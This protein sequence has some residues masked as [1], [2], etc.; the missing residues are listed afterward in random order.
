MPT[1]AGRRRNAKR[2][3]LGRTPL[4]NPAELYPKPIYRGTSPTLF[5]GAAAA[6]RVSMPAAAGTPRVLAGLLYQAVISYGPVLPLVPRRIPRFFRP[7]PERSPAF[8]AVR[9]PF[10][11]VKHR[12]K[13]RPAQ[14]TPVISLFYFEHKTHWQTL[15]NLAISG[16]RNSLADMVLTSEF[17][18]VDPDIM[19]PDMGS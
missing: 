18:I 3:P 4:C 7:E 2:L 11:P 6:A 15:R 17:V 1:W 16:Q 19:L 8:R 5:S 14:R 12:R 10:I 9:G 13:L